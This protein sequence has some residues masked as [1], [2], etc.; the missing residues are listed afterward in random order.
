[1]RVASGR[2]WW[3]AGLACVS[4]SGYPQEP[5]PLDTWINAGNMT[6]PRTA[7]GLAALQ[8]G[9]VIAVGGR[10]STNKP[11]ASCEIW[12]PR[13]G[14]W[15]VA[16]SL[17]V[18]RSDLAVTTLTT[19]PKD[20][21]VLAAGGC[22]GAFANLTSCGAP[23]LK[24]ETYD[25][26]ADTWVYT[27]PM[28]RKRHGHAIAALLNGDAIVTGGRAINLPGIGLISNTGEFFN[29]TINGWTLMKQKMRAARTEHTL[30]RLSN[31]SVIAA[32]GVGSVSHAFNALSTVEIYDPVVGGWSYVSNMSVP[33][34]DHGSALLPN[35]TILIVGGGIVLT[36]VTTNA[37]HPSS[38]WTNITNFTTTER[39]Y[40]TA[41]LYDPANNSWSTVANLTIPRMDAGFAALPNGSVL[42]AGGA[43]VNGTLLVSMEVWSVA[44]YTPSEGGMLV[45]IA[46][47]GGVVALL[48]LLVIYLNKIN[49]KANAEDKAV[50]AA[51]K[52]MRNL[53]T[54]DMPTMPA[55]KFTLP[56]RGGINSDPEAEHLL[57]AN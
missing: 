54:T 20:G 53:A 25:P 1:M 38:N 56:P 6:I 36:N 26:S 50:V 49:K 16:A 43:N 24:S 23:V 48:V 21:Y 44:G 2:A 51:P 15:T 19:G 7:F 22:T 27:G 31:G 41:E 55:R 5:G 4:V 13:T 3:L 39:L 57:R 11:I 18:A 29:A 46:I 33:R 17:N 37:S 12:D 30:A 14:R 35:G 47:D 45:Y 32:G 28:V 8:D 40:P 10:D 9:R 34:A 52:S 42:A